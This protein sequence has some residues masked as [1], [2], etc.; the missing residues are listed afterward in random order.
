MEIVEGP[1]AA[2]ELV[3]TDVFKRFKKDCALYIEQHCEEARRVLREEGNEKTLAILERWIAGEGVG[4][5][6]DEES[7]GKRA[8][9]MILWLCS[10]GCG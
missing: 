4:H 3:Q 9:D 1:M 8:H 6:Q 2:E 5:L 7:G 10:K